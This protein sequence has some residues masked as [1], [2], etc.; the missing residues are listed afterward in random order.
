MQKATCSEVAFWVVSEYPDHGVGADDPGLGMLVLFVCLL[1]FWVSGI[2][3]DGVERG[4]YAVDGIVMRVI[5]R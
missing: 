3:Q 2:E 4:I 5:G 1:D